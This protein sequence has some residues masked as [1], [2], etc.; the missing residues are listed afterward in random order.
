MNN[1]INGIFLLLTT[2]I[3]IVFAYYATNI[4]GKKTK[5]F[6]NGRYTQ[7]L[8]KTNIGFNTNITILKVNKKIYVLALQMKTVDVID[9][10]DEKDWNYIEMENNNYFDFRK[11][12]KDFSK[13]LKK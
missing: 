13:L 10:I 1:L 11:I 6:I 2:I 3:I 12:N 7:I 8:E 5:N 9:I 4:I